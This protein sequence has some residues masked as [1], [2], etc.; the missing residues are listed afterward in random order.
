VVSRVF[1]H[2]RTEVGIEF[3]DGTRLFLDKASDGVDLSIVDG[4]PG[5]VQRSE[6]QT[7][8]QSTYT[9]LQRRYLM[10]IQEYLQLHGVAPSEA[11]LQSHFQVTAPTVHQMIVTLEHKG[12]IE[13]VPGKARS[14][15]LLVELG[16]FRSQASEA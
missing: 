7:E 16:G 8:A 11:D 13:R 15:K 3:T 6:T 14:V 4:R 2:R 1:R 9:R 12:L 5:S 10:F